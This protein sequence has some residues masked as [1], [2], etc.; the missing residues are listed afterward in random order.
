MMNQT[1]YIDA[2]NVMHFSAELE[3]LLRNHFEVARDKLVEQ[4]IRWSSVSGFRAKIIFDGQGKRTTA[5]DNHVDTR[6]VDILFSSK[7]KTADM[8]IERAV[9]QSNRRD[10][11]IVVSA[12]RGITDF[13]MGKGALVMHPNHF[14]TS[15]REIVS[16]TRRS[17]EHTQ[18]TKMGLLEDSLDET[19]LERLARIRKELEQ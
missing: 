1:Y 4:V 2:Y 11:I 10:S 3:A 8:I 12:D 9:A 13:C 16:E 6:L 15:V 5:S 19:T 17:I 7:N 18:T 14:W